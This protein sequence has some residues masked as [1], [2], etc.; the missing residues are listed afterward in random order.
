MIPRF[1]RGKG[2]GRIGGMIHWGARKI[3]RSRMDQIDG[4][5]ETGSTSVNKSEGIQIRPIEFIQG[6][7]REI[8]LGFTTYTGFSRTSRIS[9]RNGKRIWHI[10]LTKIGAFGTF[11]LR[12]CRF[13]Q[14]HLLYFQRIIHIYVLD[15]RIRQT[16]STK[17]EQMR[18]NCDQIK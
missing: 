6:E 2:R 13:L 5:G 11:I 17:I 18:K 14:Q 12:N 10:W 4:I 7:C 3:R 16:E 9:N 1:G 8:G 15:V